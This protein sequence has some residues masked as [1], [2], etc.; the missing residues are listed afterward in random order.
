MAHRIM[1]VDDSEIAQ[2]YIRAALSDIGYEDVI[3][4]LSPR[5]ALN[6]ISS[7]KESPDLLLIDVMMPDIDGVELCARIRELQGWSDIPI[8]MLTS[9]TDMETL[10]HAFVAGAND[11]LT[12]PFDRIELHARMR[13][14]L[15]LKAELDRHRNGRRSQ[16]HG[17]EEQAEIAD[18]LSG[19]SALQ[20]ALR[21]CPPEGQAGL[22]VIVFRIVGL[23]GEAS[24]THHNDARAIKRIGRVLGTVPIEARSLF[25]H[26]DDELFCLVSPSATEEGMRETAQRFVAAVNEMKLSYREGW[27]REPITLQ[28]TLVLPSSA[29]PASALALG[30]AQAEKQVSRTGPDIF[31]VST[32]LKGA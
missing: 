10:N 2:E 24:Q 3:S 30:I 19:K 16:R 22:G 18:V 4:Y 11:Y 12:K 28:A 21:A 27:A 26:W 8:I 32:T 9:R 1:S 15:R 20:A 25:C 29:T 13:S 17:M 23:P 7:G 14:C 6:A 31:V 5:D